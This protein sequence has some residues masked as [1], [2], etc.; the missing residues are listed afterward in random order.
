MADLHEQVKVELS[1]GGDWLGAARIWMQHN[2]T[3]G[4]TILW[5][6][7]TPVSIAFCD[8][9]EFAKTVAIAAVVAERKKALTP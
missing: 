9:E 4:D 1:R 8:L 5:S 7:T 2:V 6:S 3:G